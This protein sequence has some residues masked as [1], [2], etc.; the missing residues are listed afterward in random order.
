MEKI[1]Q[2]EKGVKNFQC[3]KVK[4]K[5][6]KSTLSFSSLFDYIYVFHCLCM[7][8]SLHFRSCGTSFLSS[9]IDIHEFIDTK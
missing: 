9:S 4:E 5:K 1:H 7:Y 2:R 8:I 6:K 3:K